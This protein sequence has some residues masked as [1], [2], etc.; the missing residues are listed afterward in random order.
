MDLLDFLGDL[1]TGGIGPSTSRGTNTVGVLIGVSLGSVMGW[2]VVRSDDPLRTPDWAFGVIVLAL[3]FAPF[4][5]LLGLVTARRERENTG[6]AKLNVA[7]NAG[8][9]AL[10]VLAIA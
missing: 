10:V 3:I 9:L 6:I 5:I 4:E 8:V 1:V 7:V 2:L